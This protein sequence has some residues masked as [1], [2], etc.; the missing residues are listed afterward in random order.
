MIPFVW[1]PKLGKV[2]QDWTEPQAVGEPGHHITVPHYS[3]VT[4]D[5]KDTDTRQIP[6][7]L[8]SFLAASEIDSFLGML[9]R[10]ACGSNTIARQ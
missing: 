1:C 8:L 9:L 4:Q 2:G 5:P 6:S 7:A 3:E 10:S